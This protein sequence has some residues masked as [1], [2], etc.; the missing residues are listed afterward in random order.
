MNKILA[1]HSLNKPK[2]PPLP[3]LFIS[4]SNPFYPVLLTGV[5]LEGYWSSTGGVKEFM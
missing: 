2:V 3:D 1:S 4:N 5:I